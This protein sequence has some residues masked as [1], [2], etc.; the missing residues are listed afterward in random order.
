M[1]L[2]IEITEEVA[3]AEDLADLLQ[4][5]ARLLREGYTSGHYPN[6]ALTGEAAL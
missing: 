1:A 6:W 2:Q 3:T 4:G 5:I